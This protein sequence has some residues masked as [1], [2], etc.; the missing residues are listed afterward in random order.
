MAGSFFSG[1]SGSGFKEKMDK[2]KHYKLFVL[3]LPAYKYRTGAGRDGR[4]NGI[5]GR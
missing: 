1:E 5:C 2:N 4:K 3:Y